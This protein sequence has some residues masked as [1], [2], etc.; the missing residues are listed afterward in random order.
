MGCIPKLRS[1]LALPGVKFVQNVTL[2]ENESLTLL[3]KFTDFD[4]SDPPE[5]AVNCIEVPFR[6]PLVT[7]AI[8]NVPVQSE[9]SFRGLY[10]KLNANAE[11][12]RKITNRTK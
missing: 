10:Q 5:V 3:L 12:S 11:G 2:K 9:I 7:V 1:S 8:G 6:A 4:K